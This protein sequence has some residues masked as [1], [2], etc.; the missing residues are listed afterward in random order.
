MF[1]GIVEEVGAVT[2]A[3]AAS[4]EG[5]LRI[6]ATRVLEGTKLGDSIAVNGVCVTVTDLAATSFRVGLMIETLRRT[7]LG[8]LTPGARVNLERALAVGDRLG[9]HFVQGHVD[10]TAELVSLLEEGAAR[11]QRYRLDPALARYVVPKGFVTV[12]GV[13]LTVVDASASSF[14]I[15]LVTYTQDNTILAAQQPGYVA[16]V[17]V[18]ILG[19]Y[20]ERF[21]GAVSGQPGAET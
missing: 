8:R 3:S 16:N 14:S 5:E 13:S 21:V 9:G 4:P 11:V 17:E 2:S 6:L 19:K 15:S 10:G 12:D 7:N 18:D 20:V 1:S